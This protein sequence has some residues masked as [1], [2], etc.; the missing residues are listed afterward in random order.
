MSERDDQIRSWSVEKLELLRKYLEAYVSVLRK[1]PWCMGYEYIDGFAGTGRAKTKE[2][3][4]YVDGSPR[5]AL[6]LSSPFTKYH[7]IE[8]SSW[9]IDRLRGLQTEFPGRTIE[10]YPGDCNSVITSSIVPT[11]PW[12]SHKRAI[13]FLDPFGMDLEWQTLQAIAATKTIEVFIN[14]S[15]MDI[16]RNV[17]RRNKSDI[18]PRNRE[19]FERFWGGPWEAEIFR[20]ETTLFGEEEVRIE[21][22]GIDLGKRYRKRLLEIFP[23][24]TTPVLM[25]NTKHAPLYCLIFAGHNPVGAKIASDIFGWFLRMG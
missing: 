18:T 6:G 2:E 14:F 15:V 3:Q 9:R 8:C 19:R 23:H 10:I 1:Q 5:I 7:F 4:K 12:A 20:T 25:T 17:R 22:S 16:N 13:A 24:C 21:Q 11:L